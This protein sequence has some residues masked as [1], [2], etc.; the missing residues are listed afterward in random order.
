MH[1]LSTQDFHNLQAVTLPDICNTFNAAF[2]DYIVP[3][4]LTLP[5]LE[6]K[7][8]GENLRLDYSLGAFDGSTLAGFIL[9]GVDSIR[10]P[11]ILYNGGTG[12]T[13]AYR[14]QRLVQQLY[15]QAMPYYRQQGIEKVILEVIQTNQPALKVYQNSG[16][17]QKRLVH[18]YKGA[19]TVEKPGP[20]IIIT[21][22]PTPDWTLM[23]AYSDMEPSWSNTIHAVQREQTFTTSW[24]ASLDGQSAGFISVHLA[25]KRIRQICVHPGLR[26]QGIGSALLQHAAAQLGNPL[27]IINIDDNYPEMSQFLLKTGF[28][29]TLSQYEMMLRV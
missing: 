26:R 15:A 6:Q 24:E 17:E 19:I 21:A 8:Q 23:A 22:N 12:V 28:I 25:S 10:Q 7:I 11:R 13:P 4:Q 2:S 18:C 29:H 1:T 9:H 27:S 5:L 14:G 16:F 3:V 20:G